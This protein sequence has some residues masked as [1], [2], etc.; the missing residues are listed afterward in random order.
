MLE[1]GPSLSLET[2]AGFTGPELIIPEL[3]GRTASVVISELCTVLVTQGCVQDLTKYQ[4]AVLTRESISA[5]AFVNGW[6]LPHARLRGIQELKFAIGR[7]AEPVAWF[8]N[9]TAQVRMILLFAVPEDAAKA[10]LNIIA[11]VARL[12]QSGPL[13]ERLCAASDPAGIF[14]VLKEVRLPYPHLATGNRANLH[15]PGSRQSGSGLISTP[16]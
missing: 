12:T 2:L 6:A 15:R 10:Y 3:S 4:E 8:G 1:H 11:A 9:T 16:Q 7:T 13:L 5:T 14:G